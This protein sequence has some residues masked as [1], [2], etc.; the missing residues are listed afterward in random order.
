MKESLALQ[1]AGETAITNYFR[2]L[3]RLLSTPGRFYRELPEP[4]GFRKPLGF[5]VIS[6]LFYA[7]AS[8]S[9]VQ[10][11]PILMVFILTLNALTMPFIT[12][13][14]SYIIMTLTIGKAVSFERLYAVYAFAAGVTLL[15]SWIPLFIWLTEPWRWCLMAKGL[16]QGC[17]LKWLHAMLIVGFS[18]F[19]L[20]LLVWSAIPLIQSVK[21]FMS[22]V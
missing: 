17:R 19:I 8:L 16:V 15:A 14:L 12:A 11:N 6:S 3:V 9:Y 13:I 21:G 7:G 10:G 4:V 1:E 18:I 2:V 22:L 5:L 20:I